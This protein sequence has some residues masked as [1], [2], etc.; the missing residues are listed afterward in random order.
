MTHRSHGKS[1]VGQVREINEDHHLV[2]EDLGLYVVCDGM[3]GHEGGEVASRLAADTVREVVAG[4]PLG[5]L[6]EDVDALGALM[7]RA[8]TEANRRVHDKGSSGKSSRA[9]GTT[10]TALL[11]R[12]LRGVM[13]HVGDSRLYLQREGV[14]HQ[15]SEDHTFVAEAIRQGIIKPGDAA[16]STHSNIVTRAVGPHA[17]VLVDTLAFEFF[18]G[19]TVLLCSDGLHQYFEDTKELSERLLLE[20]LEPLAEGLVATAN[21]RGG[22]DNITALCLRI[23]GTKSGLAEEVTATFAT[24]THVDLF[25]ELTMPEINRVMQHL[26]SMELEAG[27][28]ICGQ[29]DVSDSLY[30]LVS[31]LAAVSRDGVEIAQLSG[32]SHFG[33]MALLNQRPR[34]AEVVA[35]EACRILRLSREAFY[36]LVQQ[37]TVVGVKFLWKLAQTL[38]LRL[39]E[40]Y[41]SP[42]Q[43]EQT[44]TTLSFGLFPSPFHDR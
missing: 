44:R 22:S 26:T 7:R 27:E 25:T 19:D 9:M 30:I 8:V 42:E 2:D 6:E 39:D 23:G 10:C 34:S 11:V 41:E 33:E 29:G 28:K 18:P 31:G 38:S 20:N 3:G 40:L 17:D 12:G 21:E 14:V 35:I 36:G 16:A 15:L 37:D 24:V 32:G 43:L 5:E 4:A 1:D 13:A